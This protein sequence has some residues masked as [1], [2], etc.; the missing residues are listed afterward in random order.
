MFFCVSKLLVAAGTGLKVKNAS[1]AAA[2]P[3]K[4]IAGGPPPPDGGYNDMVVKYT[5]KRPL[6]TNS[7]FTDAGEARHDAQARTE[8]E[9]RLDGDVVVIRKGLNAPWYLDGCHH[10]FDPSPGAVR[11]CANDGEARAKVSASVLK[12][13]DMCFDGLKELVAT[14]WRSVSQNCQK[15]STTSLVHDILSLSACGV[16]FSRR[17]N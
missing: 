15:L 11:C 2:Q 6:L 1:L 17:P 16:H 10:C 3:F 7:F 5:I 8:L 12:L 14:R 9:A 13:V 4:I